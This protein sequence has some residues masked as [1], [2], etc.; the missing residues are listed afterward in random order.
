MSSCSPYLV[1]Q[2]RACVATPY[3][4]IGADFPRRLDTPHMIGT[5]WPYIWQRWAPE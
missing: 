2:T 5:L 4:P 3:V 1:A